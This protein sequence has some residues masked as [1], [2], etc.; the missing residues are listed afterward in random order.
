MSLAFRDPT[1]RDDDHYYMWAYDSVTRGYNVVYV[2]VEGTYEDR[3]IVAVMGLYTKQR[4]VNYLHGMARR[5]K[6]R[7]VNIC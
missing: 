7:R 6:L 3:V 1:Y 5:Y 4:A 2:P